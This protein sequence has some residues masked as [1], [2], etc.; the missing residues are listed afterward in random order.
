MIFDISRP[1]QNIYGLILFGSVITGLI[2][3]ALY[4]IKNGVKRSVA[5]AVA[6]LQVLL[7]FYFGAMYSFLFSSEKGVSFF[8]A[9]LSSMGGAI[10]AV[11]GILISGKIFK[12]YKKEIAVSYFTA[13]PLIYSLSK[14]GCF[15]AGCC[16]GRESRFLAVRYP[17]SD[18]SYIPVQLMET[19][20]FFIIFMIVFAGKK[21][22]TANI[23][24]CCTA[25]FLLDFFRE[26]VSSSI[27]SVNQIACIVMAVILIPLIKKLKYDSLKTS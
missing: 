8:N 11:I 20:V 24:M 15:F 5:L 12:E 17:G 4:M 16:H 14:L 2:F 25:K 7:I 27:I 26:P 1:H 9:G 3:S 22:Q 13:I 18:V 21:K 10:G 23:A 19:I 6:G